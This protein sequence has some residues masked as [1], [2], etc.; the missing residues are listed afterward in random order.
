LRSPP[1]RQRTHDFEREVEQLARECGRQ[2][3]EHA[4]N[5]AEPEDARQLPPRIRVGLSVYR[6]NRRTPRPVAT[7]LGE[8][9]LWRCIYQA[10][11]AGEPGLAPL[12]E[13]LGLVVGV[14]TPALADAAARLTAELPQRATRAALAARHGVSWADGTLRKVVAAMAANLT[15]HR[16][17]AQVA[18]LLAW[19]AAAAR[20]SSRPAAGTL[21]RWPWAATA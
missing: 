16:E 15:P 5:A 3:V 21:P 14:A 8:I 1:T 9:T 12:D 7:L 11:E 13:A 19:L 2:T 18:Q 4:Y 6:R 10:V 17:P 20:N